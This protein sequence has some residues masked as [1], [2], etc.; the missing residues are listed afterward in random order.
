[1]QARCVEVRW[2]LM[3]GMRHVLVHPGSDDFAVLPLC[4]PSKPHPRGTPMARLYGEWG[5][6]VVVP[7]AR[8]RSRGLTNDQVPELGIVRRVR[9]DRPQLRQGEERPQVAV[10]RP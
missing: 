8:D 1:M 5:E 4:R 7:G 9:E 10:Q 2:S 6:S 3:Q